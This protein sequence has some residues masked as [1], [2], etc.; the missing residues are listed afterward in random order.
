MNSSRPNQS[1]WGIVRHMTFLLVKR[2]VVF[3]AV[4]G[5]IAMLVL[6]LYPQVAQWLGTYAGSTASPT[7]AA[8][9]LVFGPIAGALFG[10]FLGVIS[11]TAS[12]LALGLLVRSRMYRSSSS[13]HRRAGLGALTGAIGGLVALAALIALRSSSSWTPGSPM[14]GWVLFV[15]VPPIVVFSVVWWGTR[16]Y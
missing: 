8:V 3:G 13:E 11:G 15:I 1:Y 16:S 4:Y 9:M 14:L 7:V 2:G 5:L 12:S 6:M 10:L